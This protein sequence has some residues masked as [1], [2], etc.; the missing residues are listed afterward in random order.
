VDVR[1]EDLVTLQ[2]RLKAALPDEVAE[3]TP[4]GGGAFAPLNKSPQDAAKTS[5]KNDLTLE[6]AGAASKKKENE[7]DMAIF[8][9]FA[10]EMF[11]QEEKE[12]KLKQASQTIRYEGGFRMSI[13][14]DAFD[15][16]SGVL[17]QAYPVDPGNGRIAFDVPVQGTI[18]E[19]TQRQADEIQ[20]LSEKR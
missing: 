7:N 20:A 15:S 17:R 5:A 16:V 3:A 2:G 1:A 4:E 14:G 9:Q 12:Q 11:K 18:Y 13:P 19:L 6:K 8:A 10:D